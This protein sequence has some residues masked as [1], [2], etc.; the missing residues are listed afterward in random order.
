MTQLHRLSKGT[1]SHLV[2]Q[3]LTSPAQSQS[4]L[5]TQFY[6]ALSSDTELSAAV[7]DVLWD[8]YRLFSL[9]TLETEKYECTFCDKL[10]NATH[11][12]N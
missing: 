7:K 4:I 10:Q 6:N 5:V 3:E 1:E 8:L 11:C 9:S 2:E 12:A